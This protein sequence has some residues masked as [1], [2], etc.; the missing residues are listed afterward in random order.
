MKYYYQEKNLPKHNI[1][2]IISGAWKNVGGI[3]I[4]SW[5]NKWSKISF[6]LSVGLLA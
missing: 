2:I 1:C 5:H 3:T 6:D 4:I